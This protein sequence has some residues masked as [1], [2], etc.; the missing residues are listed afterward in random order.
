MWKIKG[1][2][3]CTLWQTC[4]IDDCL[5]TIF[6]KTLGFNTRPSIGV[7]T[8]HTDGRCPHLYKATYLTSATSS[9]LVY[10][11]ECAVTFCAEL[12]NKLLLAVFVS[13]FSVDLLQI[14]WGLSYMINKVAPSRL[15]F[16][17]HLL[18]KL[19]GGK[20]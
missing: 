4:G 13:S 14:F 8:F 19:K 17:R 11:L 16:L 18:I 3:T 20:A 12:V 5:A 2:Y 6:P 9:C 7:G 1:C 15:I 10:S